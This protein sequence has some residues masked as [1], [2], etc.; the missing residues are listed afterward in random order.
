MAVLSRVITVEEGCQHYGLSVDEFLSWHNAM[1]RQGLQGLHTTKFQIYRYSHR[2][3]DCDNVARSQ[4]RQRIGGSNE[5]SSC[6]G[7]SVHCCREQFCS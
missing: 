7:R 3:M 2:K 4:C 1:Q 5:Y 6:D